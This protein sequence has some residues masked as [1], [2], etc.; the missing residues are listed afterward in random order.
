M[1]SSPSRRVFI[2]DD[3]PI[4]RAGARLALGTTPGFRVC[5]EAGS[6]AE[7]L[8]AVAAARPDILILDLVLGGRDGMDF[9]ARMREILPAARIL[10]LSMNAEDLFAERALRAGA[11]GYLMKGGDLEEL[12]AAVKRIAEGEVYLSEKMTSAMLEVRRSGRRETGIFG[13]LTDR[14][15]QVFLMLGQ[16]KST[17]QVA[18]ELR[19]SIKTISTHRENLKVKL[20]VDSAAELV[21][22][23]VAY[24]IGQG[25][26]A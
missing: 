23:A 21:R 6:A 4:V 8:T 20:G 2:V 10:V 24:V 17:Q 18:D 15:M 9:V 25:R 12:V 11:N 5:G 14:E 22:Q 13:G 7:A 3:H 19:L 1:K 16:G 26:P